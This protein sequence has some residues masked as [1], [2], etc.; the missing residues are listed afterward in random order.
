MSRRA[1]ARLLAGM[2]GVRIGGA[3]PLAWSDGAVP[4]LNLERHYRADA[5]VLLLGLTVFHREDVGAGSVI[6]REFA[7]SGVRWLEF[8]AYSTPERAAGLRRVG[9]IREMA[10]AAPPA[11]GECIYFGLMTASPEESAEEAR[12]AL[13]STA[14]EQ[15]Y[16]AIDGRIGAGGAETSIAH[17]TA[18]TAISGA[19]IAELVAQARLA[20]ASAAKV[21]VPHADGV[22][23]PSFLQ[24]LAGLLRRPDGSEGSYLYA[25]RRYRLRLSRSRDARASAQFRQEVIRV[26]G[27]L[28]RETGGK[29]TEFRIWIARGAERPLP[30]RIEYRAKSYLRLVFEAVA[31]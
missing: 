9:L 21:S 25:G 6:W 17:F 1:F 30:L 26:S 22:Y 28:R 23:T 27:R 2:A 10:R 11:G 5:Q 8:S 4:T 3:Q 7:A 29:E 16:T 13:G 18:P 20:L 12:R 31:L 15:V 14:K 19:R 24:A